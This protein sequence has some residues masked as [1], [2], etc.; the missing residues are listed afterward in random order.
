MK[1]RINE[2][3][4]MRGM[5]L[6]RLAIEAGVTYRALCNYEHRGL[7]KAQFGCVAR[8]AAALGCRM[9]ELYRQED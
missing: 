5:S 3:A 1:S 8:I 9:E 7:D 6:Q 2:L 4:A